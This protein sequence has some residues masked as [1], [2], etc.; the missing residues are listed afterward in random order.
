MKIRTFFLVRHSGLVY[1]GIITGTVMGEA[2]MTNPIESVRFSFLYVDVYSFGRTWVYPESVVPYNMLRY[3]LTGEAIFFMDGEEFRVRKDE[4]VYVPRGCRLSCHALT[5]NFSFS[6]IRFTTSVYYEGGNFLSDY[7][8]IP[9]VTKNKDEKQYFEQ[10]F[11]WVKTEHVARMFFVRGNLELLIGSL[12]A[13][14]G[15]EA[16]MVKIDLESEEYN[17]ETVKRRIRKSDNKIDSRVQVVLD[18]LALHPGERY[19]PAKMA[20]MAELSSSRFR[21]LFKS[22]TGKSPSEY[23]KELRMTTAA[24]KLLV[25]NANIS[26][27]AYEVGYEDC[28]YFIREFKS[29]FG[30]TPKQYRNL[31][32]E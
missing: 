3:I 31:A 10:I 8:G 29:T 32:K 22:Q 24:R 23:L 11:S 2:A 4:I 16:G 14:G 26:D 18:Y 20:E 7:Y 13:R 9:K 19:T 17:L 15:Q 5:D 25:S 21:Q 27:I 6:S 28:N 1:S 12:I 30:L